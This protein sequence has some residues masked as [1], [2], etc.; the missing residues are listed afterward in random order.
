MPLVTLDFFFYVMFIWPKVTIVI[1]HRCWQT[2]S[3]WIVTQGFKHDW[4]V[5]LKKRKW[6]RAQQGFVDE[7]N[8]FRFL[9]AKWDLHESEGVQKI[10]SR[11]EGVGSRLLKDML[12]NVVRKL[13]KHLPGDLIRRSQRSTKIASCVQCGA[14]HF[15]RSSRSAHKIDV[16]WHVRY[17]RI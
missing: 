11:E 17:W 15:C 13:A 7:N 16:I 12:P 2:I 10:R 14:C 6:W 8:R 4:P 3:M 5:T 9:L 1:R